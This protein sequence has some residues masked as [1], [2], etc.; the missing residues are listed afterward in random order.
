MSFLF[1]V[2]KNKKVNDMAD[3]EEMNQPT[4]KTKKELVI[5]RIKAAY[6]NEDITEDNVFDYIDR[7]DNDRNVERDNMK[8]SIERFNG[9]MQGNPAA[10]RFMGAMA[11]NQ[12]PI[13]YLLGEYGED[14]RDAL[15]DPTLAK[16]IAERFEA[17]QKRE[18]EDEDMKSQFVANLDKSL[19]LLDEMGDKND[20]TREQR[21]SILQYLEDLYNQIGRGEL[22]EEVYE[23]ASKSLNY[24]NKVAT[25]ERE[26][27]IA[28]EE[29]RIAGRNEKISN[30]LRGVDTKLPPSIGQG[31]TTTKSKERRRIP[32][33]FSV[34]GSREIE[35]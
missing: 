31:A 27:E 11:G 20:W 5:E 35:I 7:S 10:A 4:P 12:D 1:F 18:A 21:E 3:M 14:L 17:K 15:E 13:E 28:R 34:G 26:K 29:G 19:D 16:Q 23:M 8:Q 6:P 33:A 30:N 32:D 9:L 24:D 25:M 2:K 22:T